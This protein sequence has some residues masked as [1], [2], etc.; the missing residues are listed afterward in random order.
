MCKKN[1]KSIVRRSHNSDRR[2]TSMIRT[3]PCQNLRLEVGAT[4]RAREGDND[5]RGSGGRARARMGGAMRQR[6]RHHVA[7]RRITASSGGDA[8]N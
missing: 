6:G 1:E 5:D 7:G 8:L 3:R 4:V 2:V